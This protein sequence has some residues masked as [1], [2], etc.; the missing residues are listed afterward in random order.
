MIA[1]RSSSTLRLW[2]TANDGADLDPL[3]LLRPCYGRHP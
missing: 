1:E 2:L 3:A